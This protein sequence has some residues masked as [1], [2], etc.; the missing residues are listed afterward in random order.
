[1]LDLPDEVRNKVIADGNAAWLDELPSVVESLAQEWSLT[2]GDTLRGGHA[3]LVVE[4]MLADQITAVLKVGVPGTR[5]DLTFEATA[6]RLAGGD[7]CVSLLRDDLDRS[8]LLLE[9]LGAAMYDVVPDPATRHDLM[10]DVAARF[11]RPVSPLVDL[12]TGADKAREYSDLL[13]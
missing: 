9:R 1:M 13:P 10:C 8:A 12:P 4:A 2:I 6:L 3:A 7:G 11:W 5:R